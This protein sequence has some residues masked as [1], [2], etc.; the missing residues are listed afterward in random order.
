MFTMNDV[1]LKSDQLQENKEENVTASNTGDEDEKRN[2]TN[3]GNL[4]TQITLIKDVSNE[5]P[6]S[7]VAG[8]YNDDYSLDLLQSTCFNNFYDWLTLLISIS[9]VAT[10][11]LVLISY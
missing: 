1:D 9:D 2:T 10:D 5:K 11:I 3:I 6:H 7:L 8:N 4:N